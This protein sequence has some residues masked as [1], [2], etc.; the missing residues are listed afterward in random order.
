M[1][2]RTQG[3]KWDEKRAVN[4]SNG[5]QTFSILWPAAS[6]RRNCQF[7]HGSNNTPLTDNVGLNSEIQ[8]CKVS[9]NYDDTVLSRRWPKRRKAHADCR[10]AYLQAC[11][12]ESVAWLAVFRHREAR[13]KL[14]K[15][16]S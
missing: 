10:F 15:E 3:R 1:K 6:R 4:G 14:C 16:F 9:Q 2:K 8:R 7:S 5:E 11:K 13:S 12:F